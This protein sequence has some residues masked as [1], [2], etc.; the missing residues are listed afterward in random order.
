M[1]N[2]GAFETL[3]AYLSGEMPEADALGFEAE[4]FAA[5]ETGAAS[6]AVF[7][8]QVSRIGRYLIGHCGFDIGSGRAQVDALIAQGLR[9]QLLTAG[10]ETLVGKVY[11]L[12]KISDDAQIVVT[13][14]PLDLRGHD[15]V[16][17]VVEKPDGTLLKR[18]REVG[19]DPEDGTVYAVCEAP[20]A[21]IWAAAGLVRSTVLGKRD[22]Q[23]HV[24]AVFESMTA[25]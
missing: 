3:D 10:P 2:R 25:P 14:F 22:G 1:T 15:S 19:W 18:F 6:E 7:V 5:A 11:Q 24:I 23:E 21:R 12:P 16:D 17:V 4:L 8:D 9:V 13:H 20:L